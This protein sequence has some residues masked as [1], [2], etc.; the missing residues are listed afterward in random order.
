MSSVGRYSDKKGW[1]SM[2]FT[3]KSLKSSIASLLKN[4][5]GSELY[6]K[7]YSSKAVLT[8]ANK[9]AIGVA[10]VDAIEVSTNEEFGLNAKFLHDMLSA[11]DAKDVV[12]QKKDNGVIEVKAGRSRWTLVALANVAPTYRAIQEPSFVLGFSEE[13]YKE[14]MARAVPFIANEETISAFNGLSVIVEGDTCS[15]YGASRSCVSRQRFKLAE[16]VAETKTLVLWRDIAA[17]TLSG[18]VQWR[19]TDNTVEVV[20]GN[21]RYTM[22]LLAATPPPFDKAIPEL[23]GAKEIVM[24]KS[25]F[26]DAADRVGLCAR[27]V[28][29]SALRLTFNDQTVRLYASSDMIGDAEEIVQTLNH[30]GLDGAEI[31][32]SARHLE[33]IVKAVNSVKV[34]ITFTGDPL[35]PLLFQNDTK[36]SDGEVDWLGV[37]APVR[38]KN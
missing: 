36:V 23:E 35:K 16:P 25:A 21:E 10:K 4:V 19:F 17:L 27:V 15:L 3:V 18:D 22:P 7:G 26:A 8:M 13:R 14:L 34:K 37:V 33:K 24:S 29:S 28:E 20:S 38:L 12:I 30:T 5:K 1:F 32:I 31:G 11:T 2:K 9:S 6:L